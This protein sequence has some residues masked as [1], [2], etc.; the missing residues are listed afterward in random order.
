MAGCGYVPGVGNDGAQSK[1]RL[2]EGL[3]KGLSNTPDSDIGT[4]G[5]MFPIGFHA[6]ATITRQQAGV[7]TCVILR[8]GPI[9]Y[10]NDRY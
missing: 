1:A 6:D 9:D 5:E 3:C 2:L 8:A 10:K 7:L 4:V